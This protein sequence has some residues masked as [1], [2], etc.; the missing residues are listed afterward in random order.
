MLTAKTQLCLAALKPIK[1]S[2]SAFPTYLAQMIDLVIVFSIAFKET[3]MKVSAISIYNIRSKFSKQYFRTRTMMLSKQSW[4]KSLKIWLSTFIRCTMT[5]ELAKLSWTRLEKTWTICLSTLISTSQS[6][7]L[8]LEV[9]YVT[10]SSRLSMDRAIMKSKQSISSSAASTSFS[11]KLKTLEESVH[12][13]MVVARTS[14]LIK[15]IDRCRIL[16]L[17]SLQ[18]CWK[19]S[20]HLLTTMTSYTAL[21][22][23]LNYWIWWLYR[24]KISGASMMLVTSVIRQRML[25]NRV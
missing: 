21:S 11:L 10:K 7:G 8:R 16:W 9:Y 24:W 4:K 1:I 5:Q 23:P 3:K 2:W 18:S 17:R 14:A 25:W 6:S 20:R 12:L 15:R 13:D 19:T 22:Q